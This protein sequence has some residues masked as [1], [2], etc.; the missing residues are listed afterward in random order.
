M[1]AFS[2]CLDQVKIIDWCCVVVAVVVVSD[3]LVYVLLDSTKN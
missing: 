1:S 2:S 3:C